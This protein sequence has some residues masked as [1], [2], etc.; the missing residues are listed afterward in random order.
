MSNL[1]CCFSTSLR[2]LKVTVSWPS[3]WWG[4]FL[5]KLHWNKDSDFTVRINRMQ[6]VCSAHN[7][8]VENSQWLF[9]SLHTDKWLRTHLHTGHCCS[10]GWLKSVK[11]P[12]PVPEQAF[13]KVSPTQR[14]EASAVGMRW[15]TCQ[16]YWQVCYT[17][18]RL[19]SQE[20][21][22]QPWSSDSLHILR[23]KYYNF[24]YALITVSI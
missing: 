1:C 9:S 22:S 13:H 7:L 5:V 12:L 3:P 11:A 4:H 14:N 17:Q 21:A 23:E 15:L 2:R 6:F 20:L 8:Q 10:W 24:W 18:N 19:K 16:I